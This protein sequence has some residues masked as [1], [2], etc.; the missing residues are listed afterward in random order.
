MLA[1]GGIIAWHDCG[2][3]GYPDVKEYLDSLPH[4]LIHVQDT[5]LA[6]PGYRWYR[7]VAH[8]VKSARRIRSLSEQR[9]A[10]KIC[11]RP[12]SLSW[13]IY[14]VPTRPHERGRA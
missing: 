12:E 7:S 8:L 4:D 6:L 11:N 10:R 5:Y 9:T 3:A 2:M 1:P 14:M 13:R